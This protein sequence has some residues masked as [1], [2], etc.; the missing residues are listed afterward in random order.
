MYISNPDQS[1]VQ[2]IFLYDANGYLIRKKNNKRTG[3]KPTSAGYS[4]TKLKEYTVPVHR[5]IYIY[6]HGSIPKGYHVDHINHDRF[7]NRIENLQ[8]IPAEDNLAKHKR[9]SNHVG[10][11][12]TKD[13]Q[14]W[15][16]KITI[17]IGTYNTEQEAVRA[18]EEYKKTI[19]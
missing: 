15:V 8:A 1:L 2:E 16:A 11:Y 14:R 9:S 17:D 19:K 10:I 12:K 5:L 6:H 4:Y 18:I 3:T 13:F 7:D